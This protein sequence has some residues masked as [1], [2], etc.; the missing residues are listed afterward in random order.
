M[1]QIEKKLTSQATESREKGLLLRRYSSLNIS[2]MYKNMNEEF[3]GEIVQLL[4][5]NFQATFAGGGGDKI[6]S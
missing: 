3:I 5:P 2:W 4:K 1:K 6:I